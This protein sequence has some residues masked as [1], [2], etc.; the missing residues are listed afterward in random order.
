VPR[1]V[2]P[3]RPATRD[4]HLA[5]Q[6]LLLIIHRPVPVAQRAH[7]HGLHAEVQRKPVCGKMSA[8]I[9][10]QSGSGIDSVGCVMRS[11]REKWHIAHLR[12]Q[13]RFTSI[14]ASRSRSPSARTA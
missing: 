10:S 13:R 5:R 9:V 3:R 4:V 12:L 8:A 7:T 1:G 14:R 11:W 6:N 2:L